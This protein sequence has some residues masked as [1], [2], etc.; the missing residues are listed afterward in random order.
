MPYK[1][2]EKERA[3]KA[4]YRKANIE[5]ERS[6]QAAWYAA[7]HERIKERDRAYY[8]ANRERILAVKSSSQEK[9]KR[10]ARY[11]ANREKWLAYHA[12][13]RAANPDKVKRSVNSCRKKNIEKVRSRDRLAKKAFYAANIE[14]MRIRNVA[15]Y[16]ARRANILAKLHSK[17]N[18]QK[19][20]RALA[21]AGAVNKATK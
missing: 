13:W 7:N 15:S 21:M 11:S 14:E 10:K 3:T 2:K 12:A 6:R 8:N 4:A 20:F 19:F 1:D 17:R 5:K 18:A 9:E 16:Y